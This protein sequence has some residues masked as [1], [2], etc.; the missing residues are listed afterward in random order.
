MSGIVQ[1]KRGDTF[2]LVFEFKD[3][4]GS[5]IDLSGCS[6]RLHFKLVNNGVTAL[7]V[8]SADNEILF[9]E[10]TGTVLVIANYTKTEHLRIGR[11]RADLELTFPSNKRVS[12]E[13]FFVDIVKDITI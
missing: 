12:S 4:E 5:P 8:S 11:Y 9:D 7:I 13:T 6:A 1:C 2:S 3:E 10:S